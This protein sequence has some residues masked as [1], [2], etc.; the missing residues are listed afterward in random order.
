VPRAGRLALVVLTLLGTAVAAQAQ[1]APRRALPGV[2]VKV[3]SGDSINVFVNGEVVPV[4]YI[5]ITSPAPG[6]GAD[7]GEPQGR[8]AL[9]FNRALVNQKNV[10]LELDVQERDAE[11]R[12]LAYVWVGDVLANAEMAGRG[13]GQVVSGGPNVRYYELLLKRQEEARGSRLGIWK[14]AGPPP[15]PPARR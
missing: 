13:F 6:E 8:E 12:L 10:R 4:R 5:G 1:D 3:L 2:V 9:A 7:G 14:N 11:G 15:P